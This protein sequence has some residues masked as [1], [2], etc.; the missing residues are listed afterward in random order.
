MAPDYF[1]GWCLDP[2]SEAGYYESMRCHPPLLL[3]RR[4]E[5]ARPAG[6]ERAA[7]GRWRAMYLDA[8]E[9]GLTYVSARTGAP[10]PDALG[11]QYV[12][13]MARVAVERLVRRFFARRRQAGRRAMTSSPSDSAPARHRCI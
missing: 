1:F 11:F 2:R 8:V 13:C 10:V 4:N 3:D 12:R 9:Q 7:H 6:L 5:C